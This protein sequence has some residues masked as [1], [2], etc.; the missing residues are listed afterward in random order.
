MWEVRL[1]MRRLVTQKDVF[2]I[3]PVPGLAPIRQ[4]S[5]QPQRH[6]PQYNDNREAQAI[7]SI[8]MFA[9]VNLQLQNII[10]RV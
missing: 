3:V 1:A 10:S 6:D 4:K 7:L 9:V 8:S 2:C 5:L